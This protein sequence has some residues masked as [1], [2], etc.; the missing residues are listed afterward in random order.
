MIELHASRNAGGVGD[1]EERWEEQ[2]A[3]RSAE[4]GFGDKHHDRDV[5]GFGRLDDGERR[6]HVVAGERTGGGT[7]GAALVEQLA[8]RRQHAADPRVMESTSRSS[9]ASS[10]TLPGTT[11]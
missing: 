6:R 5:A 9:N 1:G 10:P 7:G 4:R 8:E 2:T 3:G 11:R